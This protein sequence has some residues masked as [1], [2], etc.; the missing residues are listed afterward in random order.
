[1]PKS[2]CHNMGPT[3][4]KFTSWES[5]T[6]TSHSRPKYNIETKVTTQPAEH[7]QMPL[8]PQNNAGQHQGYSP[9]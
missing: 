3:A 5:H 4:N 6:T 9:T 7:P 1:M 8:D 2:S